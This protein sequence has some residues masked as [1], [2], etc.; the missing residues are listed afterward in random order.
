V[1]VPDQGAVPR[2]TDRLI[3]A[4]S[5]FH[6]TRPL[7][8]FQYVGSVTCIGPCRLDHLAKRWD[9][10]NNRQTIMR[11]KDAAQARGTH[12]LELTDSEWPEGLNFDPATSRRSCGPRHRT[13]R[14]SAYL[15]A[16]SPTFTLLSVR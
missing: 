13:P 3:Q 14:A 11:A 9:M 2:A 15:R 6:A 4:R 1:R 8:W 5:T 7:I 12:G 10:T 16:T